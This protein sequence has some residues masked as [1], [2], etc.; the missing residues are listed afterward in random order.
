MSMNR[1][2]YGLLAASLLSVSACADQGDDLSGE[3]ANDSE[4]SSEVAEH[5]GVRN[6]FGE[7]FGRDGGFP[8][9]RRPR[10][11]GGIFPGSGDFP[12]P[13]GGGRPGGGLPGG[14]RPGGGFPGLPG[15][16]GGIGGIPGFPGFPGRDPGV[17]QPDP[18]DPPSDPDPVDP[19]SDPVEPPPTG[20]ANDGCADLTYESFGKAFMQ[21]YCTS[22]HQG[23]SA[24]GGVDLTSLEKIAAQKGH[25]EEHAVGT[26]ASK[27]MPPPGLPQPT[28]EEKQKLGAWLACGPK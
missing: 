27:P 14:G 13:P 16:D 19:P 9:P 23:A 2:A 12:F 22:C 25:V 5:R 24:P 7:L 20:G 26:P 8:F 3:V 18:V 10:R 28:A 1:L 15:R 6:P 11:D 4:E 17:T 21:K